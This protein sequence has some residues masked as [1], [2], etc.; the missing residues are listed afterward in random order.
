MMTFESRQMKYWKGVLEFCYIFVFLQET[1]WKM[2]SQKV[3]SEQNYECYL[4]NTL[5]INI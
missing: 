4:Q 5:G 3:T 2:A 1:E